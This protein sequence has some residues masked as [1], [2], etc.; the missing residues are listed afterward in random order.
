MLLA[1]R[2]V[3]VSAKSSSFPETPIAVLASPT[4][5]TYQCSVCGKSY[6]SASHLAR[7]IIAREQSTRMCS[8]LQLTPRS[9]Q[10]DRHFNCPF[11]SKTYVRQYVG[12]SRKRQSILRCLQGYRA[13][14][15]RKMSGPSRSTT[16]QIAGS[17]A[18]S[19]SVPP[20]F[21]L[22]APVRWVRSM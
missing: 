17:W 10:P 3:S 15:L 2:I 16:G 18:T 22:Q 12:L 9:D 1:T 4:I 20:M 7:H 11:C 5:M 6:T 14:S 13:S 21:K 8:C 19:K